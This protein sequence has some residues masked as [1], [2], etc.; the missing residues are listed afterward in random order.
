MNNSP[1]KIIEDNAIAYYKGLA[2]SLGGQFYEQ[3][4]MVWF[5]TNRR[6]LTRFNGVLRTN[7]SA[8]NLP[9]VV[10]RVLD[11]FFSNNLPFFWADFPHGAVLGLGEFLVS[12]EVSLIARDMP[13]M[14][15][16]LEDLPA[17]DIPDEVE[18]ML[19]QTEQDQM[20]WLEVLMVGF[21]EPEEAREDF[22]Q[23]LQHPLTES[24]S[25]WK[26]FLARWQGIPCAISTLLSAPLAGGIY[27]VV[28]LPAY[29]SRG[30]G[31]ALTLS[32]MQTASEIGYSSAVLFATPDGFPLY[33][34]LG[35]ETVVT[36]DLYAWN[37]RQ[38]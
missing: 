7:T 15:R 11:H 34:K 3:E 16:S 22:R 23:Y 5:T 35:F 24:K 1:I 17:L 38:A 26:H 10:N 25:A 8:Q 9:E 36:A 20:E 19:V 18:I 37:G 6:S 12:H 27:H 30:L 29:R 32:A 21:P 2:Y 13:S 28:T 31:K 4:N 14:Q 33:R